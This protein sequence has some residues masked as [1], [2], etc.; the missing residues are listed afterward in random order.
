MKKLCYLI[1][2]HNNLDYVADLIESLSSDKL[3]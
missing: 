3:L 1:L 2:A